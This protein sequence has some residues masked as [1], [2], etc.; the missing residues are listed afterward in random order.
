MSD[1]PETDALYRDDHRPNLMGHA[2]YLERERD[3]WK[4][5]A[6][7]HGNVALEPEEELGELKALLEDAYVFFA[8]KH[9]AC[10]P[11]GEAHDQ[12]LDKVEAITKWKPFD[13]IEKH[14]KKNE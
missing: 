3:E 13:Q 12:W 11:W 10:R 8:M 14:R 6:I 5:K 1:T 2:R 7:L 4:T 9:K